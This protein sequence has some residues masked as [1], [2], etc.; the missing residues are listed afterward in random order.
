MAARPL[1]EDY[2]VGAA[3]LVKD[4]LG[5]LTKGTITKRTATQVTAQFGIDLRRFIASHSTADSGMLYEY[6]YADSRY[7]GRLMLA[8]SERAVQ[9]RKERSR[10]VFDQKFNKA[11]EAVAKRTRTTADVKALQAL[12]PQW[13]EQT[14]AGEARTKRL[15][16]EA[17]ADAK[18]AAEVKAAAEAHVPPAWN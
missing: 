14:R 16:A 3:V 1:P 4:S 9:A 10:Q 7:G 11:A 12:L 13:L 17:A 18:A 15:A 2:T 6:G 5:N 8:D